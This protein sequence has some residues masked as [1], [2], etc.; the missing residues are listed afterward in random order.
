MFLCPAHETIGSRHRLVLSCVFSSRRTDLR[1]VGTPPGFPPMSVTVTS[2]STQWLGEE[3]CTVSRLMASSLDIL[4][5]WECAFRRRSGTSLVRKCEYSIKSF[6]LLGKHFVF[7]HRKGVGGRGFRFADIQQNVPQTAEILH[8][9][10][11]TTLLQGHSPSQVA[12]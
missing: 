4:R 11:C 8:F 1:P 6:S 3:L 2:H 10:E 9:P 12:R 5:N 7:H